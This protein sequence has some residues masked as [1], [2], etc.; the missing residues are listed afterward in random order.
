M[1]AVILSAGVTIFFLI[2][3]FLYPQ[4]KKWDKTKNRLKEINDLKKEYADEELKKPFFI[5]VIKPFTVKLTNLFKKLSGKKDHETVSKNSL[6]IEKMLKT[7]AIGLNASEF[8]ALKMF[9]LL[10]TTGVGLFLFLLLPVDILP[11][12]LIMMLF[13]C[14]GMVGPQYYL[15]NRIKQRKSSIVRDLP[16]IMDLL[17]VSIEAGLGL[18]AA[19][20]RLY[21][22][23]KCVALQEL[24][25]SVRD[26]QMGVPRKIALKEMSDRCSVKELTSFVTALIQAEQLG[27]A[28]KNVLVSQAERLREERRQ[29]IKEKASKAPIKIMIPTIMFIFPVIF[30]IILGPAAMSL[31]DLFK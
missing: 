13:I 23:N 26:V 19:I 21:E 29:C 27:V 31:L 30:I 1:N 3:S 15:K 11:K 10:A 5:R 9:I 7:A 24:Y 16:D 14:V 4:G 22:K 20:N 17:V 12:F 8:T 28:I 6:K 2:T 18:D 25:S